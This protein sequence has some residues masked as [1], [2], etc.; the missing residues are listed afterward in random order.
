MD[1]LFDIK[2]IFNQ[3]LGLSNQ[4][5]K[6]NSISEMFILKILNLKLR[7]FKRHAFVPVGSKLASCHPSHLLIIVIE[8][9]QS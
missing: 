4:L 2:N 7:N 3:L 9:G 5:I 6:T 1:H 8:N